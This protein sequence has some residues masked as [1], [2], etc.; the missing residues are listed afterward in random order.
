MTQ[1][2]Q[3]GSPMFGGFVASA[4]SMNVFMSYVKMFVTEI[5]IY[6]LTKLW[7]A[8]S[9]MLLSSG[10]ATTS[11]ASIIMIY[12][13]LYIGVKMENLAKDF[14]LTTSSQGAALL[15]NMIMNGAILGAS[16]GGIKNG[17]GKGLF[18]LGAMKGNAKL[19]AIGGAL[20]GN[21]WITLQ[22]VFKKQ[23][24]VLFLEHYGKHLLQIA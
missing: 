16:L 2:L 1:I 10:S 24:R 18:S 21:L 8:L 22:Q 7:F 20:S 12:A 15:D 17:V 4:S 14:G 23:C 6:L 9:V 3:M 19:A 5:F 11:L 13:F